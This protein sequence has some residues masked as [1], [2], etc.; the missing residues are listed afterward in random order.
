MPYPIPY[1]QNFE[2]TYNDTSSRHYMPTM[3]ASEHYEISLV[4]SGDRQSVTPDRIYYAHSGGVIIGKPYVL[5]QTSSIS[6]TPYK[7]ILIKCSIK[8]MEEIKDKIGARPFEALCDRYV[9]YFS[10]EGLKTITGKFY[11][12]LEEY[13]NYS[14][15]S[16]EILKG[17]MFHVCTM[18]IR[19]SRSST[20]ERPLSVSTTNEAILKALDYLDTYAMN[21][22]SM[23]EVA[24]YV[25]LTPSHFS[26]LFKKTTGSTYSEYLLLTKM[27]ACR[28]LLMQTNLPLEEI[29]ARIGICNGNYL[30]NLFKKYY[31]ETP[32]QFRK[33]CI[34]TEQSD[35]INKPLYD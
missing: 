26:R 22:P 15:Y 28:F 12:M 5:H 9:H 13:K 19:Y 31:H 24:A 6:D 4:I 33:H 29:A 3:A 2:I 10:P 35:I 18:I 30:S 17:M 1:G 20:V 27:Q 16:D 25:G 32:G 8:V 23:E 14:V 21:S 11:E 34:P 7:R